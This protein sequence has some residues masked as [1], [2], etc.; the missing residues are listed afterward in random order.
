MKLLLIIGIVICCVLIGL[1][2]K[3][4]L[5][6]RYR[7]YSDFKEFCKQINSEIVFLKTDK[8]TL[9]N[10][11]RFENKH[12]N[13]FLKDYVNKGVGNSRM[14]KE[15]ENLKLNEFLDSIGKKDVS[16]EIDNLSYYES[17]IAKSCLVAEEYYNKY[18]LFA[19][20]MSIIVG[21]LI[22]IVLI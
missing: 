11:Q 4:Y 5:F 7:L 10:K 6:N 21:S 15:E 22:A 19:V 8:F 20:K 14:L 16:G 2:I 18:G 1:G 9:I 3:Q 12:I 17:Q 13:E